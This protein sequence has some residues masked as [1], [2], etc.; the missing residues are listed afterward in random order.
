MF[1]LYHINKL[2]IIFFYLILDYLSQGTTGK[3]KGV[4]LTH[5]NI[6][7]NVNGVKKL[8]EQHLSCNTSCPFLPWAHV[9]GMTCELHAG[10]ATGGTLAIIPHRDQLL[11]CISLVKP[12]LLMS[13]P[14]LFNKVT[15][16]FLHE[17]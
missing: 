6:A 2:I 17:L 12:T 7:S 9:F 15:F 13:V 1:I 16:F 11:E 10:L 5:R 3:P 14:M 8:W 4:E